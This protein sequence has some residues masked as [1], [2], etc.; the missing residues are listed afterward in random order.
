MEPGWQ[1]V[2]GTPRQG[3]PTPGVYLQPSVPATYCT[4]NLLYLHLTR[5][6]YLHPH[7]G[8][9]GCK[10][11]NSEVHWS[12]MEEYTSSTAGQPTR[13]GN[14]RLDTV[15]CTLYCQVQAGGQYCK[16]RK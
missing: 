15:H 1:V 10:H 2:L 4:F 7:T 8:T 6:L 14:L 16:Y 5:G 3:V 11:L 12:P 9:G 13:A